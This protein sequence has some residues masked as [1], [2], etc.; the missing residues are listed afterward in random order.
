MILTNSMKN[1]EPHHIEC[2]SNNSVCKATGFD[3]IY[4]Y[5]H[6]KTSIFVIKDKGLVISAQNSY[7]WFLNTA[8]L[9]IREAERKFPGFKERKFSLI[10]FPYGFDKATRFLTSVFSQTYTKN[11]WNVKYAIRKYILLFTAKQI[12]HYLTKLL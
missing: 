10:H 9:S 3:R 7:C 8:S 12:I 1:R 5:K 6:L 4:K 2:F 11:I